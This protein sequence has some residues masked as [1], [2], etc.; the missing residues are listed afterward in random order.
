[1]NDFPE[2]EKGD[3][4]NSMIPLILA[5]GGRGREISE[6]KASLV[7]IVSSRTARTT[8][9]NAVPK[10]T[11]KYKRQN[12]DSLECSTQYKLSH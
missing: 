5:L 8:K 3:T 10:Q 6:S 2:F 7:C 1:M 4:S 12:T 9:K 11:S